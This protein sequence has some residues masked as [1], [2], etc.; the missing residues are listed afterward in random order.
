MSPIRT[1]RTAVVL[2]TLLTT[3]D[4]FRLASN[5]QIER[6]LRFQTFLRRSGNHHTFGA[7]ASLERKRNSFLRR[8]FGVESTQLC[9]AFTPAE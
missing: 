3:T 7:V 6:A 8:E 1:G 4:G 9:P 2:Y 5:R